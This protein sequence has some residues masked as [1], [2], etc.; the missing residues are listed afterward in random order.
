MMTLPN[1]GLSLACGTDAGAAIAV[2]TLNF[3]GSSAD[4]FIVSVTSSPVLTSPAIVIGPIPKVDIFTWAVAVA[5]SLPPATLASTFQVTAAGVCFTVSWLCIV[6][7]YVV[8]LRDGARA[9]R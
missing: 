6:K 8:P 9:S 3:D 5:V 7:W 4:N 2:G 1:D